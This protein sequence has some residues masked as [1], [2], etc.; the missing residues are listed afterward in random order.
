MIGGLRVLASRKSILT[1]L[2]PCY[3]R[4]FQNFA[5]CD[6]PWLGRVIR[7]CVESER[8]EIWE[9]VVYLLLMKDRLL[10][11]TL[12]PLAN[13]SSIAALVTSWRQTNFLDGDFVS[14]FEGVPYQDPRW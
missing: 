10:A 3:L 5:I 13:V 6:L 1:F 9:C 2:Y 11:A 14:D 4:W 8:H 7:V 12:G